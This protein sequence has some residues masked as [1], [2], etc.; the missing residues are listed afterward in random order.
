[1]ARRAGRSQ[2]RTDGSVTVPLILPCPVCSAPGRP[3]VAGVIA[4]A[5]CETTWSAKTHKAARRL[6][7]LPMPKD[8]PIP[9]R[10]RRA[11]GGGRAA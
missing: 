4:C 1:M 8:F 9:E 3:T 7:D 11:G 10:R 6:S 5:R 2:A